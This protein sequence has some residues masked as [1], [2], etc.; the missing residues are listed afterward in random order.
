M[1][2]QMFQYEIFKSN[3]FLSNKLFKKKK[4]MHAKVGNKSQI[5]LKCF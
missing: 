2:V 5:V 1:M 4:N 3:H